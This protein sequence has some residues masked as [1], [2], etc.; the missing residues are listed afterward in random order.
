[1]PSTTTGVIFCLAPSPLPAAAVLVGD[2]IAPS[3]L[4]AVAVVAGAG[5]EL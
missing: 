1:M 3:L 4:P 2:G 5:A